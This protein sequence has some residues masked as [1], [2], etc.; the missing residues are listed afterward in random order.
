MVHYV[1]GTYVNVPG[2]ASRIAVGPD[3]TPWVVNAAG[4]IYHLQDV[5]AFG[6]AITLHI[7]I[8]NIGDRPA[9]SATLIFE[10]R[11]RKWI[12]RDLLPREVKWRTPPAEA[13]WIL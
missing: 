7:H 9:T 13:N 4:G 8:L 1:G 3:N 6:S 2:A 10:E 5:T 12:I 11:A